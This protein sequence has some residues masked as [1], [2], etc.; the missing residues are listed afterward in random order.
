MGLATGDL[1]L[2]DGGKHAKPLRGRKIE[3]IVSGAKNFQGVSNFGSFRSESCTIIV[4]EKD[5]G[6]AAGEWT[7]SLRKRSESRQ[8]LGRSR[9]LRL[10]LNDGHGP[11]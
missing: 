3:C 4:F 8:D 7:E 11:W 10:S 1:D 5:L 2:V 9:S 6:E